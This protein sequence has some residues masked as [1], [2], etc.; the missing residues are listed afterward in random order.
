MLQ[1]V[2]LMGGGGG[3]ISLRLPAERSSVTEARHAM[4][5]IARDCGTDLDSVAV[6]VSEAVGN[7]VVHGYRD[8]SSGEIRVNGFRDGA[9]LVVTVDDDG[10]GMTP[11]PASEGL[12]LGVVLI[13]AMA[14]AV[15]YEASDP[16]VRVTMRF[17]CESEPAAPTDTAPAPSA[18]HGARWFT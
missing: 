9:E 14:S 15:Q 10:V 1:P 16:G 13:G 4:F 11:N 7:A 6:A 8:G 12:G 5:D 2:A 18:P 17:P 3:S